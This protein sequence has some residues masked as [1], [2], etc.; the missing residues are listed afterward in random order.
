VEGITMTAGKADRSEV[1]PT[2]RKRVLIVDDHP[3]VRQGLKSLIDCT[4]DLQTCGEAETIFDALQLIERLK[5]DVVAVDISL[6]GESGIDL[7]KDIRIR[8]PYLPVL[9]LSVHDEVIY[10]QRVLQAGAQGYVTKGEPPETVLKALRTVLCGQ[11]FVSDQIANR[12][13]LQMSGPGKKRSSGQAV[14]LLS[15]RERQ[16]FE[17]LGQGIGSRAAAKTLHVSIKTVESHRASI[18]KK[19]QVNGTSELLQRAIEW[20]QSRS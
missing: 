19:L 14:D 10:A 9:T 13:L 6:G 5:P 3:V 16:I 17:L 20:V 11:V 1:S 12:M 8:R 7:I 15:D 2:V 18:K 4:A